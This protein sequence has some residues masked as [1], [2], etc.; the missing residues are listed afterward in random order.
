MNH[1]RPNPKFSAVSHSLSEELAQ[2]VA[3][4]EQFVPCHA[5]GYPAALKEAGFVP[6]S[7]Q[8]CLVCNG[9]ARYVAMTCEC[10]SV[11][12]YDGA[13]HKNC[14]ECHQPFQ[15]AQ[16]VS[17]HQPSVCCSKPSRRRSGAL[18][19][20]HVCRKPHPSVFQFDEQWLCLNCLEEHRPPGACEDCHT[21]QTGDLE[22]SFFEGCME[23]GGRVSWD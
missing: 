19:M 18:S 8:R 17:Q 7:F 2:R 13:Q 1:S 5:C 4:G 22:G 14:T 21:T 16:I 3:T 20:C 9:K 23:C 11:G 12:L 6:L 15:Y 10:G